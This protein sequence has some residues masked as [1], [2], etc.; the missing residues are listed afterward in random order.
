MDG[1]GGPGGSWW[2]VDGPEGPGGPGWELDDGGPA[3][4]EG[5]GR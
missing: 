4:V 3:V 2:E 5:G 1:V